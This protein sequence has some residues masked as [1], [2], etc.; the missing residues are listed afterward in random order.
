MPGLPLAGERAQRRGAVTARTRRGKG[1]CCFGDAAFLRGNRA[2]LPQV[3]RTA[4]EPRVP[5]SAM[6]VMRRA[7]VPEALPAVMP[8]LPAAPEVLPASLPEPVLPARLP[9]D[10]RRYLKLAFG[11]LRCNRG[12]S[13]VSAGTRYL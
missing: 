13:W 5:K 11:C 2:L 9:L 12:R 1:E 8:V 3:T 4:K 10:F 6:P 7:G